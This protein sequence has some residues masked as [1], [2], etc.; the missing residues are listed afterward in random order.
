MNKM[1]KTID[2]STLFVDTRFAGTRKNPEICGNISGITTENF[3]PSQ[4]TLGVL[5]GMA[6]E[7]FQMYEHM[8]AKKCGI[9]GSG[10][11]VRKNPALIK[12]LERCFDSKMKVPSHSEEAS[13]G[14]A[15]FG[16]ISCGAFKN[17]KEAQKIIRYN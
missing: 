14:A 1:L 11:A 17:S 3:N 2:K 16:L 5:E 6:T 7:L 4:L 9:V 10:N 12:V 8:G 13:V 15:M